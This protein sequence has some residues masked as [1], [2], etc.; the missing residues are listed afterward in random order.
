VIEYPDD[1]DLVLRELGVA[2]RGGC[3]A[4]DWMISRRS[5]ACA[6]FFAAPG[7]G[8]SRLQGVSGARIAA[9]GDA[10]AAA[11]EELRILADL[12]PGES[13]VSV[14]LL[15][16]LSRIADGHSVWPSF[17]QREGPRGAHHG[18]KAPAARKV[19]WRWGNPGPRPV[20]PRS[21][22]LRGLIDGTRSTWSPFT[23]SSTVE[24]FFA[25]LAMLPRKEDHRPS[26]RFASIG[27]VTTATISHWPAPPEIEADNATVEV[28]PRRDRVEIVRNTTMPGSGLKSKVPNTDPRRSYLIFGTLDFRPDPL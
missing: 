2:R 18:T 1:R 17:A 23:S 4:V 20:A 14:E 22:T 19:T 11:S 5:M 21:E 8:R 25:L 27:P 3:R 13:A 15:P 7:V 28:A 24:N 12:V 6:A 9:V 16:P 26:V 10:T